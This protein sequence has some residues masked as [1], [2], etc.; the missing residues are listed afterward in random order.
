MGRPKTAQAIALGRMNK[1]VRP[2]TW[3][4]HAGLQRSLRLGHP[5]RENSRLG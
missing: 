1:Y 4:A 2:A 3:A 5:L